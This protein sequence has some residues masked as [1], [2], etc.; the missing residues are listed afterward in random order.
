MTIAIASGTGLT[1]AAGSLITVLDTL[2][3]PNGWAKLHTGTNK[4]VYR[5]AT[6]ITQCCLFVIDTG[7]T[8]ATVRGY[9]T[10]S[11]G[12]FAAATGT[13]AFP[14]ADLYVHK[15]DS[16]T[17]REW[18]GITDGEM[19]YYVNRYSSFDNGNL[20][21]GDINTFANVDSFHCMIGASPTTTSNSSQLNNL[22]GNS[23]GTSLARSYTQNV[24]TVALNRWSHARLSGFS[25]TTTLE[26]PCPVG[27]NIFISAIEAWEGTDIIRGN[28][29]GLY[30]S[31]NNTSDFPD[32][33]EFTVSQL[34]GR[35]LKSKKLYISGL[36]HIMVFDITGPW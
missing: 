13:N 35:T 25:T 33:T 24:G 31:L 1:N 36:Y 34:P 12:E 23:V 29:P 20:W 4:A 22:A 30:A 5:S 17:S 14:A 18:W 11:A 3:L 9:E 26:Y 27:N 28:F 10:V 32:E 6:S 7:T 2:L 15:S 8:Y 21:F 16:A 19:F